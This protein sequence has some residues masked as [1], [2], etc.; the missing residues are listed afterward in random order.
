[1]IGKNGDKGGRRSGDICLAAQSGKI[2]PE[3]PE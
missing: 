3:N 2:G 1:L